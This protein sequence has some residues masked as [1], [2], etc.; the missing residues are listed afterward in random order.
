M[1]YA[2]SHPL[3]KK[4]YSNS[5]IMCQRV[6]Y[7]LRL[8]LHFFLSFTEKT[9]VKRSN[10]TFP[11][12][13][14]LMSCRFIIY[15]LKTLV[16][17]LPQFMTQPSSQSVRSEIS[18]TYYRVPF[19]INPKVE[20]VTRLCLFLTTLNCQSHSLPC[21]CYNLG[22]AP[23]FLPPGSRLPPNGVLVPSV[24]SP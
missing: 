18:G 14:N 7:L 3:F 1:L 19:L 15:H 4:L 17:L 16:F 8:L 11:R 22:L 12:S 24:D 6:Y 20:S 21:Y 9:V 2:G 13:H 23:H 10:I 5:Y